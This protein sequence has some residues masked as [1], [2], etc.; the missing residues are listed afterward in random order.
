[1]EITS[2]NELWSSVRKFDIGLIEKTESIIFTESGLDTDLSDVFDTNDGE[3]LTVLK[4]GTVRKTIA[5]ISS[6]PKY[7]DERNWAYP[8]YHLF[9]CQTMKIMFNNDRGHRYKKTMRSDGKFYMIITFDNN[10]HEEI[11]KELDICGYCFREYKK[12][13][14]NGLSRKQFEL[15]DYFK[16]S[17]SGAIPFI[18]IDHDYTSVPKYYSKSWNAISKKVKEIFS[19]TCQECGI[20]LQGKYSKYLHTHHMDGDPSRNIVSNL[21]VVC[22]DC[23]SKEFNHHHIKDSRD[24]REFIKIKKAINESK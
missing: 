6:R 8:K 24:Y 21:K 14:K 2:F 22:I 7:Y 5:Y 11:L 13:H 18:H 3:L 1:M 20:T 9:G 10:K 15:K 23:H 17:I 16:E 19:C 12:T 4:D